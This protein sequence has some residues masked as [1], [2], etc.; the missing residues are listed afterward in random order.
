MNDKEAIKLLKDTFE[1][2]FNLGKFS[3]FLGELFNGF[4]PQDRLG[5]TFA[6]L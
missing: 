5:H 4:Y 3:N 1:S 2:E 6:Y